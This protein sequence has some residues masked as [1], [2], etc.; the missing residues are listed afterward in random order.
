VYASNLTSPETLFQVFW[1]HEKNN[2]IVFKNCTYGETLVQ[3]YV[4]DFT[5]ETIQ[6]YLEENE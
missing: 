1:F 3:H 5:D 4:S 2:P 6:T